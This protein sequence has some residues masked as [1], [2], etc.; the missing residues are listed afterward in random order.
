MNETKPLSDIGENICIIGASG[1]IGAALVDVLLARSGVARVYAL[2]RGGVAETDPRQVSM[3][4]DVTD[5]ATIEAAANAID[6]PLDLI[7][8][9][10]G[11]LHDEDGVAP[12]KTYRGLDAEN[13]RRVLEVNTVG[14][15]LAAKHFLPKLRP[16]SRSVFAAISARVGSISDNRLGGW[17]SYRASK[18]ALNMLLK[19]ASIEVARRH[20]EAVIVGLHPGT[21]DTGLSKPFQGNVPDGKLFSP[22]HCARQLIG[23]IDGLSARDTG[24]VWDWDGSRVPE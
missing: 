19:T 21:V 9:A 14:P 16:K 2:S 24:Q 22:E 3:V 5:E 17:Y 1:G 23:V 10:T 13:L 15:A 8:I 18:T 6:E 11:L 20:R 12:E 4:L 7:I